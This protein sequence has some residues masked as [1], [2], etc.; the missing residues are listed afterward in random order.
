ML[1]DEDRALRFLALTGLTPDSLR[2]ALGEPATLRAVIDFL[3]A[4]EPDLVAAA[5]VL[6]VDPGFLATTGE[7]LPV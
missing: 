1:A 3:C 2:D 7:R 6:G 4:H 5:G